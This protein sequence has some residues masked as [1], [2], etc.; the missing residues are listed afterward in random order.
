MDDLYVPVASLPG[1]TWKMLPTPTYK[2]WWNSETNRTKK[3]WQG[4]TSRVWGNIRTCFCWLGF[5]RGLF[6]EATK[7]TKLCQLGIWLSMVLQLIQLTEMKN[8]TSVILLMVQ[9]LHHLGYINPVND[10]ISYLSIGAGFLPLNQQ[11]NHE[12]HIY[13]V[14]RQYIQCLGIWHAYLI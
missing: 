3:C 9:H 13:K 4:W 10:G 12:S 5:V 7:Y 14:N 6:F 1:C 11:Q 8:P 2:K